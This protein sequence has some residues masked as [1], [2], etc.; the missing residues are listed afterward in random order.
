MSKN[1]TE[2]LVVT[3]VEIDGDTYHLEIL[4]NEVVDRTHLIGMMLEETI[5]NHPYFKV[6]DGPENRYFHF[7]LSRG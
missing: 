7:T 3:V 1:N 2:Q 6:G 5:V 4:R